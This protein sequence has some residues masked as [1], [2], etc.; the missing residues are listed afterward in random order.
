MSRR[1]PSAREEVWRERLE[2]QRQG[3]W[4]VAEFCRREGVSQPAFYQWR[5]RLRRVSGKK[6]PARGVQPGRPQ[7]LPV[8]LAPTLLTADVCIEL[9]GG[10]MVRLPQGVSADLVAAA[11]RAAC[12]PVVQ[13]AKSSC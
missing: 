1:V 8:E 12:L 5:K 9:P 2:R 11:V 7:F 6:E 10:A 4:S 3:A 13:E